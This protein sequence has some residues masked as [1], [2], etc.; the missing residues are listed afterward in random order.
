MDNCPNCGSPR[1]KA[2]I[3]YGGGVRQEWCERCEHMRHK[4]RRLIKPSRGVVGTVV[5]NKGH[6]FAVDEKGRK[7]DMADT[8][9]SK[10]DPMGWRYAGKAKK[11]R[12]PWKR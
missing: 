9:Y 2:I 6:E 5:D 11:G 12:H 7:I 4:E 1:T 8:P 3:T 10:D